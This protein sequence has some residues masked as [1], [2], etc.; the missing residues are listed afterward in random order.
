MPELSVSGGRLELLAEVEAFLYKEAQ[1]LDAREFD[2]WLTLFAEDGVYWVPSG[3][4]DSDPQREVSVAYDSLSRLRERVWR[5]QSGVA[6]AQEPPSRTARILSNVTVE[7]DGDRLLVGS[8]FVLHEFRR[9]RLHIHAGR[10]RHELRRTGDALAIA[11]KKVELVNND[12]Y[13]GNLSIVL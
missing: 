12:G 10:Y 3:S 7:P 9:G 4:D 5:L 6:H 13:L 1:L 11:M 2:A 8:V